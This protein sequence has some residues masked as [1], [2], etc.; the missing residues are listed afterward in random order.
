MTTGAT[1]FVDNTTA[2]VFIPEKWSALAIVAREQKLLL[3]GLIDRRYEEGL[4][5]GDTIHVPAISNLTA[6]TK[7]KSTNAAITFETVTAANTD[8]SIPTWE[9]TAMAV[10][11]NHELS[12]GKP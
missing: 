12:V 11:S 5:F 4:E 6:Q 9:Y 8:I 7:A 2:D 3:A 10:E 1:E